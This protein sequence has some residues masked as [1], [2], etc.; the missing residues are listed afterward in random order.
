[1]RLLLKVFD[2]TAGLAL[3]FML[4]VVTASILTR[5][6]YGLSGGAVNLMFSGAIELA[7]YSLLATV[8]ASFPRAAA[9]GLVSVD[10]FTDRLPGWVNGAL[11]RFWSLVVA[12]VALMIAY[13]AWAQVAISMRR[14]DETQDLGMAMYWFYG[15]EMVAF[16]AFGLTAA[17]VALRWNAPRRQVGTEARGEDAA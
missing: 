3:T 8:V 5:M 17:W 4:A 9:E 14:N 10:I 11:D 16:I 7:S 12:A 6:L 13:A 15:Y 2:W 1:M